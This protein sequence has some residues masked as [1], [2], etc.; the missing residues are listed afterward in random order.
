MVG[1]NNRSEKLT[2][3]DVMFAGAA[4]G[5]IT[6][7]TCQPL[8]VLKIRFQLQ[9]EPISH[10]ASSKY[11]S[12][13]QA[14]SLVCKEEGFKALWKGH[15]PAQLLSVVYGLVQFWGFEVLTKKA[16]MAQLDVHYKPLVNFSCGAI[17][18]CSATL[19]SFPFDVVRTRLIAQSDNKRIYSGVLQ[20]FSHIFRN[21][22]IFVFYRGILPTF[23]QVAPHAGVQFMCYK[24]FDGMYR[25]FVNIDSS[26]YSLS[27][28]VISGSLAGLV[29]KTSIYPL[30]L[31]KKRMQVQGIEQ[32]RLDYGKAFVCKGMMDCLKRIYQ[33]EG[34]LGFFKGLNPSL[35]KAVFTT[36]LHFSSYE[37]VCKIITDIRS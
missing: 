30:D 36:A 18:G 15:I 28:T 13:P 5:F 37:A 19:A 12:I 2:H 6:R 29:A 11:R 8:D 16:H 10:I 1:F 27:G 35:L 32:H 24:L 25:S 14:I 21:E 26:T 33:T 4:S 9:V 34:V 17:S 23:I 22:G 7:A 31:V 20:A 3:Y